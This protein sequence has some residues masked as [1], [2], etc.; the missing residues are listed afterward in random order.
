[1]TKSTRLIGIGDSVNDFLALLAVDY[2][3]LMGQFADNSKL[4]QLCRL[5]HI[6]LQ[7][8]SQLNFATKLDKTIFTAE[9]WK[10]IVEALESNV[11]YA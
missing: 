8:I 7:P 3:I 9:N 2:G 6:R 11:N 1:M 10:S 5:E 4:G